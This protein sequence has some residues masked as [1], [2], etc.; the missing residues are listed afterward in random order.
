MSEYIKKSEA[1]RLLENMGDTLPL[2]CSSEPYYKAADMIYCMKSEDVK[3]V[4][5]GTW[6]CVNE[7]ENVY[8]CSACGYEYILN[9]GTPQDNEMNYCCRCGA[10]MRGDNEHKS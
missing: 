2:S 7:D 3:P 9:D 10:D 6:N 4:V 8:M 5:H 1:Y